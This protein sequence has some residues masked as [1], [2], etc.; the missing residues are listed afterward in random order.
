MMKNILVV[1]DN[2]YIL[3]GLSISL[4]VYMKDCNVL[5]AGNG[6]KAI[7]IVNAVPIDFIL[8]DL[9]MPVMD[10]F[11]FIEYTKKNH[12]HIPVMAMTGDC[13]LE[14]TV[15]LHSLGVFQ[16]VEKPFDFE[17]LAETISRQLT[18]RTPVIEPAVSA[19][20]NSFH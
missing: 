17:E 13:A 6:L 20:G 11:E 19:V 18:E 2:K 9:Q 4:S 8:T 3:D 15:R 1:D 7:E 5:T 16:Y 10:G 14:A 12:P